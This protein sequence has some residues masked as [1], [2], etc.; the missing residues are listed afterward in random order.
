M[1]NSMTVLRRAGA[2]GTKRN[3]AVLGDGFTAADQPVYNDWVDT[4]LIHGVFGHDYYSEDASGYNIYRVNLE[5]ARLRGQHPD[6]R[7]AGHAGRPVRRHDRLRDHALTPPSRTVFNG[8]WAH[9][10]LKTAPT[11]SRGCRPRLT[12]WVPDSNEVLVVLNNP[13][14]GGC[15]GGG[16][17]RRAD[18]RRLARSRMSSGTASVASPTSIRQWATTQ[19]ASR[20]GST[21]RRSPTGRRR[22]GRPFI[23]P[24]TPVPTGVGTAANYNQ[25]TR[26]P[27][28]SSNFDAGL[29]E[30]GGTLN[31]RGSTAQSRTAG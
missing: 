18:G 15:G 1:A 6:V 26:P 23:D 16:R 2:P 31:L 24:F 14:Y 5:S 28:W 13:N 4:T 9:C 25:G 7:R 19:A 27:T 21:S 10:W 22:S 3:V 17:A 29:F 20:A 30:G 11:P 12:T 8:S